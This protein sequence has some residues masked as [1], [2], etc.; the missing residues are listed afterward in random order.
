MQAFESSAFALTCL[1]AAGLK[2]LL[3]TLLLLP[4]PSIYPRINQVTSWGL[5]LSRRQGVELKSQR[6]ANGK[7]KRDLIP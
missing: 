5:G 3:K 7:V 1:Q 4:C 2:G 6:G